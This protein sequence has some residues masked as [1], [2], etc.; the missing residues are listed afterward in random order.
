MKMKLLALCPFTALALAGCGATQELHSAP[1]N[2][3][4]SSISLEFLGSGSIGSET[5]YADARV[6]G[7]S[8]IEYDAKIRRFIMITDDR[9]SNGGSRL[10]YANL[11]SQQGKRLSIE[12][13]AALPL[14]VKNL[15]NTGSEKSTAGVDGE[16]L[17]I[18]PGE[19]LLWSSEGDPANNV[20]AGIFWSS[21]KGKIAQPITL[22]RELQTNVTQNI[23]PRPNKSFEGLA[24]G[25]DRHSFYVALEAP[26]F[27]TG[28]PPTVKSGAI[29]PI[30]QLDFNSGIKA[31][32]DYPLEPIAFQL[33][34]LLADNGISEILA[35]SSKSFLVLERSGSQ[36]QDG[37][38]RFVTRLFCAWSA[39]ELQPSKLEKKLVANFNRLGPFEKANFEGMT[40]GP[41]L[42]DG[43]TT[44]Y[45]VAD[46]DFRTDRPSILVQFAISSQRQ[47]D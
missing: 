29:A 36:Q 20:P 37:S 35:L 7:L 44:L 38:F 14:R 30:F 34:G 6:G 17:R 26:L 25:P 28:L 12:L 23:G 4:C 45:L 43:R 10:L 27:G 2:S 15:L 42:P 33:D 3:S 13:E 46:N 40:F 9:G 16:A 18:L 24:A 39:N 32:F 19:R 5:M 41:P 21:S 8:G 47:R 1:L 31:R 22:P 11:E